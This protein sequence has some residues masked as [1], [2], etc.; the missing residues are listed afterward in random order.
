MTTAMKTPERCVKLH[1]AGCS[2]LPNRSDLPSLPAMLA[3]AALGL[4]A[5]RFDHARRAPPL[6]QCNAAVG[7]GGR[8][9]PVSP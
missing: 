7:A 2:V 6:A 3:F 4:Q 9:P 1:R 5:G 8:F